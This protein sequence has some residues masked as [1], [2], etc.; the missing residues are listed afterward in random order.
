ME[1][2]SKNYLDL[3]DGSKIT[4]AYLGTVSPRGNPQVSPVWFEY[5]DNSILINTAEGRAKDKNMRAHDQV[6]VVIPDPQNSYRFIQIF[7][8]VVSISE[9]GAV[10]HINKLSMFYFGKPFKFNSPSEKRVV[11]TIEILKVIEH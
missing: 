8:K 9:N 7:G 5:K 2:I 10:D 11:F 6:C 1:A 4:F 3:V